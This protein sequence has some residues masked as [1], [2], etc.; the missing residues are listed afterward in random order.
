MNFE[1]NKIRKGRHTKIRKKVI[2]TPEKPRLVVYKSL[3]N[4]YA[5]I[6]DDTSASTLASSSTIEKDIKGS[7][8]K[9]AN[10][11]TA[12]TI[13]SSIAKKALDKNIKQ[14]VFDRNGYP[15]HGNIK[16]LADAAREAGLEF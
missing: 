16:I 7:I 4:I 3:K 10:K 6:V 8:G 14:V 1:R 15:Y 5:Q 13:G 2:G 11:E 12:K 9:S